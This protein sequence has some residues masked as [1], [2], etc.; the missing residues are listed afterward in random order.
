MPVS[1]HDSMKWVGGPRP[2]NRPTRRYHATK[3]VIFVS[4]MFLKCIQLRQYFV[5]NFT[6]YFQCQLQQKLTPKP[7]TQPK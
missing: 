6:Q 4:K 1:I 2:N 7:S 3:P 5:E